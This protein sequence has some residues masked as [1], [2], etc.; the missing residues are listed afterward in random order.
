MTG[1]TLGAAGALESIFSILALQDQII[2]PTINLHNQDPECDLDYNANQARDKEVNVVMN[3][4][5][6][7]GGTNS[8]LVFKKSNIILA[9][10]VFVFLA[11]SLLG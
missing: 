5:F 10:A 9:L 7:F 2:P 6:G 8:T 4:S 11:F 1:H 3:N